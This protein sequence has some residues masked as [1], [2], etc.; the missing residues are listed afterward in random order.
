MPEAPA[1]EADGR[2][3]LHSGVDH[4]TFDS[5]ASGPY[6]HPMI[7]VL[8]LILIAALLAAESVQAQEVSVE[9]QVYLM[10]TVLET[11]VAASERGVAV[12]ALEEAV[13]EVQRLE[14]VLSSWRADSELASINSA[15]TGEPVQLS[16]ELIR[17]L[18]TA[19]KWSL[20]SGRAFDPAIGPLIDAWD[21]RGPGR[22]PSQGQL[23]AALE[24]TGMGGFSIDEQASTATKLAPR[25]WL[26]TG[27]F[28]KGAALAAAAEILERRGV[29]EAYLDFGGQIVVF[30]REF[31]IGIAHPSVRDR[32]V[33][34][35]VV[36]RGSVATSSQS[37][38]FV[39]SGGERFGHIIDPRSGE[40]VPAW[41]SVTVIASDPTTADIL[42]TA[43]FVMGPHEGMRWAAARDD[44]GVLFLQDDGEELKH[45]WNSRFEQYL[46]PT[47]LQEIARR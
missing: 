22:R 4:R 46:T 40:P 27:G 29:T 43:L 28:G 39:D 45:R 11:H 13:R 44:V 10:G 20:E 41:G 7:T 21:L 6:Y 23:T 34:A 32:E 19:E 26:D 38:R 33:L 30:G 5:T 31:E 16:A 3:F 42:S 12:A 15:P 8:N 36:N 24:Q 1:V 9:R 14:S 25:G 18:R 37:E 35:V 47:Q 2:G 17:L